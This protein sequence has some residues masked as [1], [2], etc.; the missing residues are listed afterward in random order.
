MTQI[1]EENIGGRK[2]FFYIALPPQGKSEMSPLIQN[3]SRL[4]IHR[5]QIIYLGNNTLIQNI[6]KLNYKKK[7]NLNIY[8]KAR[9][10]SDAV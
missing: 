2:N 4:T 9:L 10:D 6:N 7:L 8:S 1:R 5:K 3:D